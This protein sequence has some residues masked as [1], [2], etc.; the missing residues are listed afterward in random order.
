MDNT[1]L[2]CTWIENV[3]FQLLKLV[4]QSLLRVVTMV[5]ETKLWNFAKNITSWDAA[6]ALHED[7]HRTAH[8]VEAVNCLS[9]FLKFQQ[10]L[11]RI[12]QIVY[13]ADKFFFFP[14]FCCEQMNDFLN[15]FD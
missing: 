14:S 6:Q 12:V 8:Q 4:T 10:H 1:L 5:Y 7:Y 2:A 9:T 15:W 11:Y 3:V 13:L